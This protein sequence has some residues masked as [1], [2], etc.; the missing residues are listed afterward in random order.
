[1]RLNNVQTR[2]IS[3]G[4]AIF[5]A[6]AFMLVAPP[7]QAQSQPGE[8]AGGACGTPNNNGGGC[9]CGCGGSVLVNYTDIG[10]SYEQSDDSDHDKIDDS[11]D[12]CV[13]TPNPDQLDDDGDGV[14]NAC[15]NCVGIANPDQKANTCGDIWETTTKNFHTQFGDENT[16]LV[17]GAACDL[18]CAGSALGSPN[19][20]PIAPGSG[21]VVTTSGS[22]NGGS[23][24]SSGEVD[25][26]VGQVGSDNASGAVVIST[27]GIALIGMGRR[28]RGQRNGTAS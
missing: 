15:D 26:A 19:T 9:G 8:C 2:I 1:M 12:N 27:L 16:G 6:A 3:Y 24:S 20:V 14:G 23:K 25:C 22:N 18:A 28:R 10:I 21:P 13:Y 5:S 17:I 11:L 7:A 4:V